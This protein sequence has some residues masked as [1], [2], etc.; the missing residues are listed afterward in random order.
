MTKPTILI[1][2]DDGILAIHLEDLLKRQGYSTLAPV[3]SGEKAIDIVKSQKPSI[4][5]M[6]IELSGKMN[7]ITA[8][9]KISETTDTPVIFLTGFSQDP[10]LEEA[11]IV[12][13]YGYLVKPVPERELAA[14]IE[15]ALYKHQLDQLVR[16]SE[17]KYRTLI[18]QASDGIFLADKNGNYLE[19]N[20]AFCDLLGYSYE[21]MLNMNMQDIFRAED[22]ATKPLVQL[23]VN[24]GAETF[25]ERRLIQKTGSNIPVEISRKILDNGN[26]QGI[27]RD[28]TERKETERQQ[29]QNEARL[30]ILLDLSHFEAQDSQDLLDYSLTKAIELTGSKIGYI[31][32]Y[33][34]ETQVFT[35]SSWSKDGM[36]DCE[37]QDQQTNSE[38]VKTGI[39]GEAVRQRKP[40]L[41]NDF[42]APDP[43][44]KGYPD[45]HAH[46]AKFLTIP[47]FIDNTIVAVVCVANKATDYDQTDI[48]QL[49][50]MMDS[51]WKMV[52][53]KQIQ[54]ILAENEE[55]YRK[56]FENM[57][58]GFALHEIILDDTGQPIDYRFLE[59]NQAFEDLTGL[60]AS[61]LIDHTVKDAL[62]D[63]ET[64][65]IDIYGK[66]ALTGESIHFEQLSKVLDKF[67][68]VS[69]YSPK[70]G[71]FATIFVDI[72][73]RKKEEEN[74]RKSQEALKKA[75][76]VSHVGSWE[77]NIKD[78]VLTWS[79]EMYHIFGIDK[80]TFNGKLDDVIPLRIHPDDIEKVNSS[81]TSVKDEAKPVPLEYRVVLPDNTIR[82]VWG[83]AGELIVDDN[84]K[85]AK[86]TGIVQDITERIKNEE[87]HRSL[88]NKF[89][90]IF[91]TTPDA[92]AITRFEDGKFIET[93]E[94]YA[95]I[96]GYSSEELSGRTSVDIHLWQDPNDRQHYKQLL[97]QH[98]E[99][100]NLDIIFRNK[101]G[102]LMNCLLS[103]RTFELNGET[104]SIS[105]T[106]DMTEYKQA[107]ES[108]WL[109]SSAL[110][111]AANAIVITDSN[112]II[113][114]ANKAF[115]SLS[116]YDQNEAQ[117]HNPRDLV[118]SGVHDDAFYKNMWN[119]ILSG[120]VWQ[121]EVINRRKDN[122]LYSEE[123][124][125]TPVI[126][127]DG[128]VSQF[129]AIKQD[130]TE[131]KQAQKDIQKSENKFAKVFQTT[132]DG[133]AITRLKDGLISDANEGYLKL[134]GFSLNDILGKTTIELD[135]WPNPEDRNLLTKM[136]I[137]QGEV[138]D[139]EMQFRKKNGQ[140]ITCLLSGRT[141]ELDGEMYHLS[142]TRDISERKRM[143][144]SLRKSEEWSRY[145]LE[146][147]ND[148][149]H[150]DTADDRI[151]QANSRFCEM[152]GYSKEEMLNM[153]VADLIAPEVQA[154]RD[155]VLLTQ[156]DQFDDEPFE[157][158]N[159][160]SSGR[161]FPVEVTI[162]KFVSPDGEMYISIVRDISERK[163]TEEETR[164]HE[165]LIRTVFE[166]VPVGIFI[167][168]E[169][170]KISL[171]NRAGKDIWGD[172]RYVDSDGLDVYKGWWRSTGERVS[173][174][175]WGSARAFEKGEVVKNEEIEIECFN[176]EH[177]IIS[178]SAYPL[179][180][181]NNHINGAVVVLQDIT[182]KSKYD[183]EL[184]KR[185]DYLA[186][187]QEST[188]ELIEELD[189]NRLLENITHRAGQMMHT[190]ACF[191][192]LINPITGQLIPH[193]GLGALNDSLKHTVQQGEGV[194]GIVWQ[195][196]E[197]LLVEEYDNWEGR[198]K[199]FPEHKIQSILGVPLISGEEVLGVL[200]LAHAFGLKMK[201]DPEATQY[202]NQFAHLAT[203]AIKNAR[204]FR[205]A[206][207]EL[208]DRIAAEEALG[209]SE[210]RFHQMF[211]EHNAI[212]LLIDPESLEI[213]DANPAA[214][215]FYGYSVKKLQSMKI[216]EINLLQ[217]DK[218]VAAYQDILLKSQ[219]LFLF[220]HRLAKGEVRTVEVHS[221]PIEINGKKILFSIIHDITDRAVAEK[222]VQQQLEELRR[223]NT[224]TLGRETRV[225]E[226]KH[227]VNEL[228]TKLG[229][230][231]RYQFTKEPEDE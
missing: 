158:I 200:G 56:L 60:K 3:A 170:G 45:G 104:C 210:Q 218:I 208:A 213:I 184:R 73:Q 63:T 172:V 157:S 207:Q 18:E 33:N 133:I 9:E 167:I 99:I 215:K 198:I 32:Y 68:E 106:R 135:I 5:L 78:D 120:Q 55:K 12:A 82:V 2:E 28:I 83:E 36:K 143:E 41:D 225:L 209:E 192:D 98:G 231:T 165:K 149:I 96:F 216:H 129:I 177:K 191:L 22:I 182:E 137:E 6:D 8:A 85:P 90:K 53:R 222:Q 196:K 42:R 31:Y 223:W 145:I 23:K 117:G 37:V 189:L 154:G 176:G 67:Y 43:L 109:Q 88:E 86:L 51:V 4:V 204:L 155:N 100:S 180:D 228:L 48:L 224:I 153:R 44:K 168:N 193:I 76:A 173:A 57:V 212:M 77:W 132:P 13:P 118:K 122:T 26:Y 47:V 151:V 163:K 93:N 89:T 114:W 125:I 201:F 186:A 220:P 119:T 159:I 75:Q 185:N 226:L 181:E 206:Q 29:L 105:I 54:D 20:R 87:I 103:A 140:I 229:S 38:L 50:L 169:E 39:W 107:Q 66:V 175:E 70:P 19:V 121:G 16:Q 147:A 152:M 95:K 144:D 187:M 64:K 230:P 128:R 11:K 102:K 139:L 124:T 49:S 138:N 62:P 40:I 97:K 127:A 14:T 194:A 131:R 174:H 188:Y 59:V 110:N 91:Q 136:L 74:I 108:I 203:I 221:S 219:S 130:V 202:L 69:A 161:R 156:I 24:A 178:N 21:E 46:L 166:T 61:E 112:G 141:I 179:F 146:H 134:F 113:Q 195:T 199:G 25:F 1:V 160:D 15:M 164:K 162:S 30:Q 58:T 183:E 52:E 116:G 71:Q 92:I 214:S 94:N 190:S 142:I 17:A 150:I 171:L 84:G 217:I 227:E 101:N 111:A 72:T 7:G 211:V 10:M 81:N 205:D 115:S 197:P 80:D 148:G 123:M 65:W 27:V 79:D 34:E 35:L 126:D